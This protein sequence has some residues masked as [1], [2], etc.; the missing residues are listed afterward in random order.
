MSPRI[1]DGYLKVRMEFGED[2]VWRLPDRG[3]REAIRE[4]SAEA[5]AWAADRGATYGQEKAIHKALTE[6]GYYLTGPRR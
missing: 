4:L 5:R 1:E 6:A 2:M 3:D